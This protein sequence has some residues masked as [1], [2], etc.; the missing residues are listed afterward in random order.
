VS[1]QEILIGIESSAIAHAVSKSN[2]LVGAGLNIV[3]VLGIILLLAALV[4]VSLRL[5]GLALRQQSVTAVG[6]DAQR[7]MWIGLGMALTSGVLMFISSARLYYYN[8]AFQLKM[9]LFALALGVQVILLRRAVTC[10]APSSALAR[11]SAV[12]ALL[13]WFSVGF[14]GRVIAF[15]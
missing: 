9:L 2:H 7:L 14:S 15:L 1:T 4:M 12:L 6:R 10:D 8:S 13:L 11:T 3:H 5:L